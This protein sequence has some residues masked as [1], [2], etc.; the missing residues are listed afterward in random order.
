M[1]RFYGYCVCALLEFDK[2]MNENNI[3]ICLYSVYASDYT[4]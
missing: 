1:S 3:V 4:L 2:A